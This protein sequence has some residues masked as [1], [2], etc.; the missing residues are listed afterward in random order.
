[1]L[2]HY[3]SFYHSKT[4][5]HFWAQ[6]LCNLPLTP[7]IPLR[8]FLMRL[9]QTVDWS[10]MMSVLWLPR[11]GVKPPPSFLKD[12]SFRYI[13]VD[14]FYACHKITVINTHFW[15]VP[16]LKK[17]T[18]VDSCRKIQLLF[19]SSD[20]TLI[21]LS[22]FSAVHAVGTEVSV[23]FADEH[24]GMMKQNAKKCLSDLCNG[25]NLLS[26]IFMLWH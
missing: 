6:F 21:Y 5:C 8:P 9:Q 7:T 10:R 2:F 24:Q 26:Y 20:P 15:V 18:K 14:S 11:V 13:C 25:T 12:M 23:P 16:A 4:F 22:F 3:M 1:M 17:L 19:Y